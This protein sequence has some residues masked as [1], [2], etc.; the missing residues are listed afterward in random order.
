CYYYYYIKCYYFIKYCHLDFGTVT[1]QIFSVYPPILDDW[2][3]WVDF[4]LKYHGG[5]HLVLET[6]VNLMK[7]KCGQQKVETEKKVISRITSSERAHHYSDEDLPE[8]PESSPDE[9]FGSKMENSTTRERTGKKILSMVDKIASSKYFQGASELKP[10]KK[11]DFGCF[12]SWA[13]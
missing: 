13:I 5:I 11:V 7:L 3:L 1:P 8:S 9:D 4:E 12:F 2:G 10:V 6:R